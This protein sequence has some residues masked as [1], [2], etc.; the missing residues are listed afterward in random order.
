MGCVS[1]QGCFPPREPGNTPAGQ[2]FGSGR[3]LL[4]SLNDASDVTEALAMHPRIRRRR[5]EQ[6]EVFF[7][8]ADLAL[9]LLRSKPRI[10]SR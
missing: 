2:F 5:P 7:E 9:Q 6:L 1:R 8:Y 3:P 10:A 4:G